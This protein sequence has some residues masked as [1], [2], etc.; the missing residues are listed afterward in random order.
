MLDDV[1]W[2]TAR[3]TAGKVESISGNPA[4]ACMPASIATRPVGDP[5]LDA[6]ASGRLTR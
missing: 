6:L 5:D 2:L 4:H 3:D 1:A